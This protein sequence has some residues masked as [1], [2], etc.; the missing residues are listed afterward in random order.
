VARADQFDQQIQTLQSQNTTAQANV[1]TLSAQASSYQDEINLLQS[2]ISSVEQQISNNEAKQAQLQQEIIQDQAQIVQQKQELGSDIKAMYIDGQM[3]TIEELATSKSLSDFVD[4]QTYRNAVQTRIQT[5]LTQ[6]TQLESQQQE[7]Q[8]QVAQLLQTQQTQQTQLYADQTQQN[9]LLLLNQSQQ[10]GYNAQIA[11]NASQIQQL[12]AEQIAANT[13]S[14]IKTLSRG[15][16]G[17]GYPDNLCNAPQDSIVDP[18]NMLNRECVSYAAWRVSQESPVGNTLLQEYNFGN[19]T[20]W[21]AAAEHYG[22]QYGVTVSTTP[23]VGD[24]AIRPAIP[25]VYVAPGDP[26]VGHAMYIEAV[27]GDGTITVSEFNEYLDGTYSEEI[28]STSGTYHGS[29]YQLQF[30]HFP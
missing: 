13:T 5:M 8:S 6:I 30:I 9:Q 26:D 21:P 28:R 27:N 3:T 24:I 22:A 18:W 15:A 29:F 17:G 19:A 4:A 2:Q 10:A 14:V 16:C 12:R 7:Q 25:G 20:N 1:N 23:E 11:A